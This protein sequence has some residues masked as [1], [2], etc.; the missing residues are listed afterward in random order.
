MVNNHIKLI[1]QLVDIMFELGFRLFA[2][3][4]E[5]VYY[6]GVVI[7]I[8]AFCALFPVAFFLWLC[9]CFALFIINQIKEF[10]K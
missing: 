2:L 7:A 6:L 4:A 3:I 8:L 10:L 9:W 1:D 5:C